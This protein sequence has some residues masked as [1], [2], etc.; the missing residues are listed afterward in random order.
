[1]ALEVF[2][3]GCHLG[4]GQPIKG[5]TLRIVELKYA[6]NPREKRGRKPAI[7]RSALQRFIPA[8]ADADE[9]R[10]V[11]CAQAGDSAPGSFGQAICFPAE[12]GPPKRQKPAK[13]GAAST[14]IT[15]RRPG[16][17]TGAPFGFVSDH[18]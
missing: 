14:R 17:L 10:N 8:R 6:Y 11:D 12:P 4:Y 13:L 2:N 15:C 16:I 1:M 3:G 9:F 18:K 5:S 7:R